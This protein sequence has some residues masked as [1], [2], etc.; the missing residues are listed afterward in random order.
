MEQSGSGCLIVCIVL[1]VLDFILFG[2]GTAI[3][4]I[5]EKDVEETALGDD[6]KSIK[7]QKLLKIITLP[8]MY[9]VTVQFL[10]MSVSLILGGFFWDD[11]MRF[12]QRQILPAA[13]PKESSVI[14]AYIIS[15]F[16]ILYLF[17]T[18]A[19]IFPRRLGARKSEAFCYTVLEPIRFVMILFF[20]FCA[21]VSVS[22]D[23]LGK[24]FG[25][26]ISSEEADVTEDEI[27]S[28]VNE[29]HEQGVLEASEAEMITNIFEFGDKEAQDIMTHRTNIIGIDADMTLS[30][31][32]AFMLKENKSRYPVYDTDIDH[33]IGILHF[34]DAIRMQEEKNANADKPIK[35]IKSLLMEAK[36]IPETRNISA[37]F[38]NMQSMKLQMVIVIDE[39]G[40][41][42][43]LLAMEDI[44]EEIVGNILDEHDE[45]EAHIREKKNGD[46][47]IEGMTPI[48]DVEEKLGISIKEDSFETV[49]GFMISKMDR[50]PEENERFE[51]DCAGYRFKILHVHNKMIQS[52]LVTKLEE[53][54][55]T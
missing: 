20:P 17:L 45:D 21:L 3:R 19:V 4:N 31:S 33:I 13:M 39:Y 12:V 34:K 53:D 41:T 54:E 9:I 27:I 29:G 43:G 51:T 8:K 38:K 7:A 10:T 6:A 2:F 42:A 18:F 46:Y 55:E 32:I 50:I 37:L 35:A 24:L 40:Q 52:V 14:G 47:V 28:M 26:A 30:E 36:F 48:E 49:N 44:L 5:N 23:I 22:A 1:A 15:G 11:L 16:I 25:M